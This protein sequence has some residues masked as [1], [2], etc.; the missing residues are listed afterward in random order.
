M[1]AAAD[2]ARVPPA[3]LRLG[4]Q[5]YLSLLALDWP[6]DDY[7]VAVKKRVALRGEASSAVDHG[8][9]AAAL[10]KVAVPRRQRTYVVVHRYHNQL[11]YKRL[12]APAFRMIEALQAGRTLAAS[13]AAAG[14]GV[15]ADQVRA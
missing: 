7:V 15:T 12:E 3:R 1:L 4:L 9:R 5:P 2:I 6:V 14:R 10:R 11:Y 8:P 13:V